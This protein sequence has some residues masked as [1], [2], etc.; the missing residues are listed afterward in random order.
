[1]DYKGTL[2]KIK[3]KWT[4]EHNTQMDK[5]LNEVDGNYETKRFDASYFGGTQEAE[6]I[7]SRYRERKVELTDEEIEQIKQN[8]QQGPDFEVLTEEQYNQKWALGKYKYNKKV[9]NHFEKRKK[10]FRQAKESLSAKKGE[11]TGAKKARALSKLLTKLDARARFKEYEDR[12]IFREVDADEFSMDEA[13][14]REREDQELMEAELDVAYSEAN[15]L[16]EKDGKGVN[17]IGQYTAQT[18]FCADMNAFFRT[19]ARRGIG[20][21]YG[22]QAKEGL[23]KCKLNRD[24][25]VRRGVQGVNTIA[26]MLNLPNAETMTVDE[27]KEAFQQKIDKGGEILLEDKGFVSTS[28]PFTT[29]SYSAGNETVEGDIGIEFRILAKKGTCGM[30]VIPISNHKHETEL[31]LKPGTKFKLVHAD[32]S[33]SAEI[34]NGNKKSWKI[35]LTTVPD[36]EEGIRK[37]EVA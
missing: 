3:T 18:S 11:L 8:V 22:P 27:I 26:H 5:M 14:Q 25:V 31:L 17:A 24:L 4:Q 28:I 35:Y 21:M 6:K 33:G 23:E 12:G 10:A 19:G 20:P 29:P 36:S 9:K 13:Y 16:R 32:M 30:N 34:E 7:I 2:D 15:S 1:M 37:E